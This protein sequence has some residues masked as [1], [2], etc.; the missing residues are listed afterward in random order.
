MRLIAG[1]LARFRCTGESHDRAACASLVAIDISG[2]PSR[3]EF[4]INEV[5]AAIKNGEI[6]FGLPLP[7]PV[8]TT[9]TT[10]TV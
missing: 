10:T 3:I 9:T 1:R 2:S 6:Y 8:I 4:A 5:A 7:D